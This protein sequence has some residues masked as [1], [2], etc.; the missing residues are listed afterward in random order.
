MIY[1][2]TL[3][4]W[5]DVKSQEFNKDSIQKLYQR[6]SH[7]EDKESEKIVFHENNIVKI[8]DNTGWTD[9]LSIKKCSNKQWIRIKSPDNISEIKVDKSQQIPV[10]N[11]QKISKGF[12]GETIYDYNVIESDDL[13]YDHLLRIG[14]ND[15]FTYPMF[16]TY[17]NSL[18]LEDG[19]II[20]T[21]SHFYNA[22]EFYLFNE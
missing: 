19:Y 11:P 5:I 8:K 7:L 21:K 10:Y 15:I 6:Y 12:H 20:I 18:E 14:A 16:V 17:Q 1:Y 9:I 3:V 22:D 13:R 4:K 2:S